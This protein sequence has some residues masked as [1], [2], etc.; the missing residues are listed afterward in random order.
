MADRKKRLAGNVAGPWFVDSSCIDCD[1]C[2][3]LAPKVF[4][5]GPEYAL[6]ARQPGAPG[7][8]DRLDAFRAMVACPV[9]AIG[10]EE[11]GPMPFGLFPMLLEDGV[12][13]SGYNSKDS[14]GANSYFVE[15][16]EGNLLIDSPRWAKLLVRE[17]EKRG[18]IS[19]ILLT[20]QDDVADADRYQ[21]HFEA[22]VW[23]HEAER[24]AAPYATHLLEGE[25]STE[26]RPG[27]LAIPVPGHTRGST[28]FLLE[29]KFL[30]SGDSLYWSRKRGGLAA[31][32]SYCWYSWDKQ[33]ESL[34]R[35]ADY[36][37]EWV[38][39]GHGERIRLSPNEARESLMALTNQFSRA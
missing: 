29:E 38:L 18:G 19:D 33:V 1:A 2:R 20:H 6:V 8:N 22:R 36:R 15:R 12:F 16:S 24:C 25:A 4:S 27:L 3:Q 31:S 37:F 21:E 35:L 26:I 9:G 17:I 32:K 10:R 7:A 23:I 39:A 28:M 30:F 34:I 13:Y 11:T 14:Y 5:D